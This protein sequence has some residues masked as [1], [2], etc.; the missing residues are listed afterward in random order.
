MFGQ[1][2]APP[3]ETARPQ[4]TPEPAPARLLEVRKV[5]MLKMNRGLDQFLASRLTRSGVLTVVTHP[6]AADAVFTD[7]LGA[8]FEEEMDELYPK[9][10]AAGDEEEEAKEADGNLAVMKPN[11]GTWGGGRGTVFLVDRAGGAVLWSTYAPTPNMQ[12]KA[13]EQTAGKITDRFKSDLA[14]LRS[15]SK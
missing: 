10:K 13:V 7:H 14:R 2:A 3:A 12:P 1:Q 11:R 6:Q 5:Y 9:P 8:A 4:P 15:P